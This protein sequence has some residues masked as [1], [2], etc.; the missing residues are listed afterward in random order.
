ML[1]RAQDLPQVPHAIVVLDAWNE[2]AVLQHAPLLG[3]LL[4]ASILREDGVTTGTHRAVIN[5]RSR[6]FPSIGAGIVIG[7]RGC[8][9]F[10]GLL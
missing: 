6:P 7:R 4:A 8:W 10:R 1:D 2:I 3:R 5:L 9:L